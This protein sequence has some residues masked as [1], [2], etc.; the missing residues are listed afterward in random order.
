MDFGADSPLEWWPSAR[1]LL[2][3]FKTD[4]RQDQ[5][6]LQEL[7]PRSKDV[8]CFLLRPACTERREPEDLTAL[9]HDKAQVSAGTF[10]LHE[11]RSHRRPGQH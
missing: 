9:V 1:R 4:P 2:L 8:P 7:L 3:L 6:Q 11:E 10:H 5:M